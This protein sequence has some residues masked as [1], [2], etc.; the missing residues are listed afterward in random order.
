MR[1]PYLCEEGQVLTNSLELNPTTVRQLIDALL[2]GLTDYSVDERG[3]VGSWIRI[4]SIKGLASF[5]ETLFSCRKVM[6][7]L[8]VYFTPEKY[9]D[10]VSGILKQGVE[11]LDN[12]RLHAGQQF[13]KVLLLPLPNVEG[14][15]RWKICGEGII[16]RLF[17]RWVL[18]TSLGISVYPRSQVIRHVWNGTMPHGYI[19]K[20]SSYWKYQSTATLF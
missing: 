8:E 20:L 13:M 2:E 11:R 3:D 18:R 12:V 9:H 6:N 16:T 14:C 15:E 5:A 17:V 7:N 19:H 10:A 4:A 1:S